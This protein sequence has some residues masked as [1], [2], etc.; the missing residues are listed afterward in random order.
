MTFQS[1]NVDECSFFAQ[2]KE[3]ASPYILEDT[4]INIP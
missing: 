1:L 3:V 2:F 4:V